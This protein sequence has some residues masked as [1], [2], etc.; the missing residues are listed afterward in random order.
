MLRIFGKKTE[1]PVQATAQTEQPAP[2]TLPAAVQEK[3]DAAITKPR[4]RDL[5]KHGEVGALTNRMLRRAPQPAAPAPVTEQPAVVEAQP[6]S[7]LPSPTAAVELL[8]YRAYAAVMQNSSGP[9]N[10]VVS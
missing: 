9:S 3:V 1:Q 6:A 10:Y 7:L 5:L 2:A 4:K 8:Q